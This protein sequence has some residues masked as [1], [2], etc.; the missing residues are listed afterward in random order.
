MRP[1]ALVILVASV[2]LVG[3]GTYFGFQPERS[4]TPA[5]WGL[6]AAPTMLLAAVAVVRARGDGVLADLLRPKWG[7]FSRAFLAAAGL[8]IAAYGFSRSIAAA[9]TPREIWVVSLYGQ[10]GDPRVLQSHAIVVAVAIVV[11]AAAE[12]I[13]WRGMVTSILAERF[14]SRIAWVVAAFLYA[15]AHVPTMW[16]LRSSGGLD[17]ILPL[18]ALAAGLVFGAMERAFGRLMP[19][20]LAHALFDWGVVMMFPLW[21]LSRLA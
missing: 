5:F 4:G 13:V 17:P 11:M 15:L 19:S 18:A 14:G 21:G 10:I 3:V 1:A 8:Y 12:E 16:S 20:I 2:V 9:G 6:V 7:D